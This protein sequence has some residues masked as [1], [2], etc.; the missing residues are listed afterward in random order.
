MTGYD[1]YE[2]DHINRNGLDNRWSNLRNTDRAGNC[3][4]RSARRGKLLPKGV[5]FH[6]GFYHA[7]I[8]KNYKNYSLGLFATAEDAAVAYRA[9]APEFH[10][11]FA[12][13]VGLRP[14]K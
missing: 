2:V 12:C 3:R 6:R 14:I 1:P 5:V 11:E 10:G 7:R 4:N 8:C 9:A 13:P